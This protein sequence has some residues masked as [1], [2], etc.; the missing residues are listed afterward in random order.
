MQV[1]I[2]LVPQNK[3]SYSQCNEMH[4]IQFSDCLYFGNQDRKIEV[5]CVYSSLPPPLPS[6][7]VCGQSREA[8]GTGVGSASNGSQTE[9][10]TGVVEHWQVTLSLSVGKIP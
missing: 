10:E 3:A 7:A 8:P 5:Y 9:G 4:I 2:I 1:A 6:T